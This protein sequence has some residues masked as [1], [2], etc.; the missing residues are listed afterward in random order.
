MK[1]TTHNKAL[2]LV[3]SFSVIVLGGTV[4]SA[5]QDVVIEGTIQD[6]KVFDGPARVTVRAMTIKPGEALPWHYHPGHAFNVVK[7]G[8]ETV[9]DGCGASQTLTPGQG[10]EEIDGRVHRGR[11]ISA[12][13][14]VVYDTFITVGGQ[15]TTV[16]IPGNVPR[17]GPPRDADECRNGGWRKFDH[18]QKF[19]NQKECVDFARRRPSPFHNL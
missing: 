2:L 3:I 12:T 7:S 15:P 16:N 6:S 10:F 14:V 19:K 1:S 17:C 18:P 4:Y 9:D 5:S 8:S 11:N 13:D